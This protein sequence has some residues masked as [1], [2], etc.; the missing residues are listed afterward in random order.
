[1]EA[2][3]G[4]KPIRSLFEHLEPGIYQT[5]QHRKFSGVVYDICNDRVLQK[6]DEPQVL[7]A[8]VFESP[9]V[10][11]GTADAWRRED[12]KVVAALWAPIDWNTTGREVKNLE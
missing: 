10:P 6:I 12:G 2:Y 11:R 7:V 1:M 3:P 4:G 5:G 9:E 8:H